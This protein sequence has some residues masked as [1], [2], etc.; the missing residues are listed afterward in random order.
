MI[1]KNSINKA[2]TI[3]IFL[4][5]I[6][7]IVLSMTDIVVGLNPW[8]IITDRIIYVMFV[9]DYFARLI[10]SDNK[11]KFIKCNLI[12][13]V[14]IVPFNSAFRAFRLLKMSKFLKLTK[15]FR[16]GAVSARGFKRG[17]RFLNTNGFKYMLYLTLI[18]MLL[19]SVGVMY[20]ENMK[21]SDA[22]WWSFVTTT[23]VGYG[24]FSPSTGIGRAI[25]SVLMLVGIGLI[26]S[27]TS[28]I[29]S[30]FIIKPES[31]VNTDKVDMVITL[32]DKL[33]DKE[34]ELF[35]EQIK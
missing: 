7:S 22:L 3:F 21:F 17:K 5:A 35:N 27:L 14:S 30:Y 29:T 20:F 33:S 31:P 32:Y 19:S 1:L 13:L 4:L 16:I 23:T 34:K 9:I 18:M 10:L 28:T 8:Q 6:L 11:S 25:A 26:G 15:V 2:Y 24:D 12:D